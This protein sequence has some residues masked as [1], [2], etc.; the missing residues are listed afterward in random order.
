MAYSQVE[1]LLNL[2][3][4]TSYNVY[5]LNVIAMRLEYLETANEVELV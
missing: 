5:T 1:A 4:S 3:H 2:I